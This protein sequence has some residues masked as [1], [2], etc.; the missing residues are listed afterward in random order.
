MVSTTADCWTADN[1]KQGYL[2]MT[3]HWIDVNQTSGEWTLRGEAV[4]FRLIRG[5]HSGQNLG[6]YF[7]GLCDRV[8]IMSRSH[9]KVC[10]PLSPYLHLT[11]NGISDCDR[12]GIM[13][14]KVRP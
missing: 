10:L 9:S 14:P 4:G 11:D 7:I 13:L 8:G 5:D 12:V 6:R 1:T 3:A 2:G